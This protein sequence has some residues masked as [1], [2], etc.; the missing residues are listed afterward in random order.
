MPHSASNG[1]FLISVW[2]KAHLPD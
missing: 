2:I 1:Q